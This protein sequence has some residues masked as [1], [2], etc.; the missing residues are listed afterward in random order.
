[1]NTKMILAPSHSNAKPRQLHN[2][3]DAHLHLPVKRRADS[4]YDAWNLS[5]KEYV[6]YLDGCG[7]RRGVVHAV[8]PPDS[9]S[10]DGMISANRDALRFLDNF[11]GR[12]TAA[13][14]VD[15]RFIEESL[16]EIEDWK[17]HHGMAWVA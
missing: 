3:A 8:V 12:F 15:F 17:K 13:C 11:P 2:I 14:A 4:P 5:E 6:K 1:M 7:I 16:R 10:A 9:T